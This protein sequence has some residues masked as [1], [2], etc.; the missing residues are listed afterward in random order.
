MQTQ[1]VPIG[2]SFGLRLPKALL[3]ALHLGK[4]SHVSLQL[5][6][7][8]IVLRPIPLPKPK[9]SPKTLRAGWFDTPFD[10]SQDDNKGQRDWQTLDAALLNDA[11][12]DAEWQW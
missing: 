7:D 2:N 1:I 4:A 12:L 9:P 8:S 6:K 3:D 11:A 5:R 10:A